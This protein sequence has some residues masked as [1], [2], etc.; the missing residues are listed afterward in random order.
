MFATNSLPPISLQASRGYT[1]LQAGLIFLPVGLLQGIT[2]PLAGLFSDRFDAR[3]PAALGLAALPFLTG[4][5]FAGSPAPANQAAAPVALSDS[6]LDNVTAGFSLL[7]VDFSN[8]SITGVAV[9]SGAF[10]CGTCYLNV[11]DYWYGT[12][13]T[14]INIVSQF[15]P[16][17]TMGGGG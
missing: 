3:L 16:P 7:E 14:H 2:A 4:V 12:G 9:N 13:Q 15:G 5:A 6:Q 11:V 1:R 10:V 8:T 17:A